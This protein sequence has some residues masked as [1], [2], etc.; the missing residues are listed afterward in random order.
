MISNDTGYAINFASSSELGI[1]ADAYGG[2]VTLT[3]IDN[4]PITIQ[5]GSKENGYGA[6]EGRRSDVAT[7]G[8]NESNIVDGKLAVTGNVYVDSDQ[9][10]GADGLLIN[11]VLITEL[12]GQLSTSDLEDSSALIDVRLMK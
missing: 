4:T 6:N 5:A 8:F 7:M 12:D 2:F 1:T 3:S 9:L 10:T 11:D